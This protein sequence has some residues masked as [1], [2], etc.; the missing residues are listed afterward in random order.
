MN[1]GGKAGFHNSA[2]TSMKK[3]YEYATY[4]QKESKYQSIYKALK[5][6][7]R[8]TIGV[9]L[10]DAVA[11]AQ[12]LQSEYDEEEK[13]EQKEGDVETP[14]TKPTSGSGKNAAKSAG[15]DAHAAGKDK[16]EGSMDSLTEQFHQA[17]DSVDSVVPIGIS[18]AFNML[19]SRI[20]I[21]NKSLMKDKKSAKIS[22][23]K[24]IPAAYLQL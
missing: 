19:E 2:A 20:I 23:E 18:A 8:P 13:S 5:S 11:V 3:I 22:W 14:K 6:G 12:E 4:S 7:K 17:K 15:D 24:V 9:N 1:Y 10:A 21:I 16:K